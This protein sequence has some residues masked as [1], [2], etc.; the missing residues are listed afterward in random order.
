MSASAGVIA[1]DHSARTRANSVYH[2]YIHSFIY[3]YT[4]EDREKKQTR[5]RE[6]KRVRNIR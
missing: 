4:H 3:T 6:R 1:T 2:T 5:A